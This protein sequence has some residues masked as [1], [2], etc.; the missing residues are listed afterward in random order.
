MTYMKDLELKEQN[1]L[2]EVKSEKVLSDEKILKNANLNDDLNILPSLDVKD[3]TPK[4]QK[5]PVSVKTVNGLKV[6]ESVQPTNG[7]CH[8]SVNFDVENIVP[9]ELRPLLPF[10]SV[11][12]TEFGAGDLS[13]DE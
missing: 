6:Y 7:I 9:V 2:S 4:I 10:F 12:L 1:L 11:C 8:F 13:S 3:I 5:E